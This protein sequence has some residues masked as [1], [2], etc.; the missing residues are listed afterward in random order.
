MTAKNIYAEIADRRAA[1]DW[2]RVHVAS[3]NRFPATMMFT[4]TK[5][6]IITR[7]LGWLP[8]RQGMR[9]KVA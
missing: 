5:A 1:I 3:D 7:A 6:P 8:R 2:S 9:A 4:P